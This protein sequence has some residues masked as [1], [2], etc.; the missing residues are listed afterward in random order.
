MNGL[1]VPKRFYVCDP[2]KNVRCRGR[3]GPRCQ[4]ECY[5]TTEPR[6]S[7]NGK[8]LTGL[9]YALEGMKRRMAL[10]GGKDGKH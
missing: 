4:I 6:L 5:C 3:F 10:K 1:Q 7:T 9:E 2:A 8:A